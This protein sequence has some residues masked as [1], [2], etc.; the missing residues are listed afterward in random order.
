MLLK[1]KFNTIAI[2]TTV[3]LVA[4]IAILPVNKLS[5]KQYNPAQDYTCSYKGQLIIHH[6]YTT[7]IL[8]YVV[9]EGYEMEKIGAAPANYQVKCLDETLAN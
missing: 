9:N 8:G 2:A 7:N 4:A 3:A 6:Y 1:L 5:I